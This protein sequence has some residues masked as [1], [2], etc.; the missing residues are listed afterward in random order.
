MSTMFM[1]FALIFVSFSVVL[2]SRQAIKRS[3]R[4]RKKHA[5]LAQVRQL[6]SQ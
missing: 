5:V 2:L 4:Q 6:T 1:V 3:N